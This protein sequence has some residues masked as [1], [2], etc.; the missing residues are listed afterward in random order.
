MPEPD[1]R[2][3][4]KWRSKARHKV[5]RLRVVL[6]CFHLLHGN[7]NLAARVE[8]EDLKRVKLSSRHHAE[9]CY[10][11]RNGNVGY[12]MGYTRLGRIDSPFWPAEGHRDAILIP[13]CSL[14]D[15]SKVPSSLSHFTAPCHHRKDFDTTSKP[16]IWDHYIRDKVLSPPYHSIP[17]CSW[18]RG[19][20]HQH[21][22]EYPDGQPSHGASIVL[23]PSTPA[24]RI[25]TTSKHGIQS[26]VLQRDCKEQLRKQLGGISPVIDQ[27]FDGF[28][29]VEQG[30]PLPRNQ[31]LH[32]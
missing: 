6:L 4:K 5:L 3:T 27:V 14:L 32:C 8:F 30:G 9:L 18:S 10:K 23:S 16:V 7:E 24:S 29:T 25:D 20:A 17:E 22:N 11:A 2:Q 1:R 28:H 19:S 31:R 21:H 15:I 13:V 12:D 26:E